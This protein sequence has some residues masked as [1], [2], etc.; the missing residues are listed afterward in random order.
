MGRLSTGAAQHPYQQLY[1]SSS[2]T[3]LC[4]SPFKKEHEGSNQNGMASSNKEKKRNRS[5]SSATKN[6]SSLSLQPSGKSQ[7]SNRAIRKS[8]KSRQSHSTTHHVDHPSLRLSPSSSFSLTSSSPSTFLEPDHLRQED[9][10]TCGTSFK[11][12]REKRSNKKVRKTLHKYDKR[13]SFRRTSLIP[14]ATSDKKTAPSQNG[15]RHGCLQGD[16][17]KI[18]EGRKKHHEEGRHKSNEKRGRRSPSSCSSGSSAGASRSK[19]ER[20]SLVTPSS[21]FIPAK[22]Q[23]KIASSSSSFA[24]LSSSSSSRRGT[25]KEGE[26]KMRERHL[27]SLSDFCWFQEK[28][29]CIESL[30]TELSRQLPQI[31]PS[32]FVEKQREYLSFLKDHAH[33]SSCTSKILLSQEDYQK[34]FLDHYENFIFDIDGVLL[35]GK[36]SYTGIS[37]TL[38]LLRLR[39]KTILFVTNSASKSRRICAKVLTDAGIQA[40]EHEIVT[41]SYAAAQ[42]IRETYPD[43]KKVF[44]IGEEGLKEELNLAEI[45]VVSLDTHP[46]PTS[47]TSGVSTPQ[48]QQQSRT[49]NTHSSSSSCDGRGVISIESEADFRSVSGCLDPSIGAVVVGWDR[50]LSF[51]K[52]CL[53][54]L[55]LQRKI[56]NSKHISSSSRENSDG[57]LPFIAAN[58]DSY[59]MVEAY[60]IPANGAAVSY[61]EAASTRKATCVGKPSEWLARWLVSRHL[62]SPSSSEEE[63]EEED[64]PILDRSNHSNSARDGNDSLKEQQTS[65]QAS[66][67]QNGVAKNRK[68]K[69]KGGVEENKRNLKK[70]VVCGDRLDTD[71]ELGHVMN[72]DTCLVLTGCTN[73][74]VFLKDLIFPQLQ[75]SKRDKKK[76]SNASF[77]TLVLPHLGILAQD[78][79]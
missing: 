75:T 60:K 65:L 15:E 18:Q 44:M 53:A 46:L 56:E 14:K 76:H 5:L 37:N 51:S 26:T 72:V 13:L 49:P 55:Y 11:L 54:S 67:K 69:K 70:T 79:L 68:K 31:S 22:E 47:Q 1:S 3:S 43:V 39:K 16:I 48:Q 6:I 61:L 29:L 66:C 38:Q 32:R 62:P 71:I 7:L 30:S 36:Q 57:F 20:S 42:Y 50:R 33:L 10:E 77:P 64:Q 41:A 27:S 24:L 19:K 4:V 25:K 23:E 9:A 63:A 17:E 35:M 21:S 40:Y 28:C 45:Q 2:P 8:Q 52:L 78:Q 12:S 58:R 74:D 59:D 73:L 34:D